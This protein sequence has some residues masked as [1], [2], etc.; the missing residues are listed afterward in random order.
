MLAGTMRDALIGLG[1]TAAVL[2][3]CGRGERADGAAAPSAMAS[4]VLAPMPQPATS[5]PTAE[6]TFATSVAVFLGE[7]LSSCVDVAYRRDTLDLLIAKLA[8]RDAGAKAMRIEALANEDVAAYVSGGDTLL[9]GSLNKALG[10]GTAKALRPNG[11]PTPLT[12]PCNE[13]F[14]GRTV[15]AT[16]FVVARPEPNDAGFSF[17]V[18]LGVTYYDALL[19]D[20]P[21]RACLAAKGEWKELAQDSL[22]HM[23]ARHRQ[24][25]DKLQREVGEN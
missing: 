22:E 24:L 16:C 23:A 3:A 10:A 13:Q 19:G 21:M 14:A 6:P 11:K 2:L 12:K 18:A 9:G 8:E 4:A 1:L 5:A 15:V 7:K 20:S 17:P 25:Y